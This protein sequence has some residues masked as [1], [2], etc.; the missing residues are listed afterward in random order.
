[1]ISKVIT[2]KG[3]YGACRYICE[4]ET[5]ATVIASEGIRDYNYRVMARDFIA[6][7]ETRPNKKEVV[8]HGILS[9]YP[10]EKVTDELMIQIAKE[11][12]QHLGIT[13]TQYAITKH[14]DTNHLHLHILAN[15]VNNAGMGI[16][17]SFL[18]LKGKKIAQQLTQKY[19]LVPAE[20]KNLAKTN[21]SA[22]NDEGAARYEIYSA[23]TNLL[24]RVN[25]LEALTAALSRNGIDTR[26][27]YKGGTNE[28][29]GVSFKKGDY[30]FKGS[31]IDRQFSLSGLQK[32]FQ[33]QLQER[34]AARIKFR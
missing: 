30:C 8:F 9:F 15:L 10:G 34:P 6:Q 28:V 5:R 7:S 14:N 26:L 2:G 19:N 12:L 32:R 3:F 21:L 22:L 25:N 13:D 31:S 1:M 20:K 16:Q 18:G 29:Q 27:K 4:D 33:Q 23:I 24:P 17:T 11:Y